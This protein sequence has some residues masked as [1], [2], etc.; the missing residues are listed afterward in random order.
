MDDR[1][2]FSETS[3]PNKEAFYSHLNMADITGADY[4][5]TKKSL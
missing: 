5:H 2:K 3:L 1:E 4:T